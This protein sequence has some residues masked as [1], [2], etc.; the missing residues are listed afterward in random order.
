[1][2]SS[3]A[4]EL[5]RFSATALHGATQRGR[6]SA[7]AKGR[8]E[9]KALAGLPCGFVLAV[10]RTFLVT[11]TLAASLKRHPGRVLIVQGESA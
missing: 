1:M 7:E 2:R 3:L 4:F 5:T 10:L 8:R 6:Y 9:M 11:I